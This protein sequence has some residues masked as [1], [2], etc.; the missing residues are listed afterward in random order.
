MKKIFIVIIILLLNIVIN[1][2]V[3]KFVV[4]KKSTV[5]HQIGN[6]VIEL[7][8]LE[9]DPL[10]NIVERQKKYTRKFNV[11]NYTDDKTNEVSLSYYFEIIYTNID[12]SQVEIS[13][14][15]NNREVVITDNITEKFLLQV[16]DKQNDE[17]EL[18]VE[19][20]IPEEM[21][22]RIDIEL[23]SY[24]TKGDENS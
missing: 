1:F 22:G 7:S 4:E 24:Q 23:H 13:L 11:I 12:P 2:S 14:T 10:I 9:E 16:N 3:S 17:Y 5:T 15:R 19:Y 8:I 6:P 20:K 21:N 18:T